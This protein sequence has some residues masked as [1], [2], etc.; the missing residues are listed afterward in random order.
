ML[1]KL[2]PVVVFLVAALTS[3]VAFE[4]R[5]LG[6]LQDLWPL[7]LG[8]ITISIF[9]FAVFRY[10]PKP[11]WPWLVF[12]L[13]LFMFLVGGVLG[14]YLHTL[15]N[16]TRTRS[17]VPDLI[18][19]PG[20]ALLA[21]GLLGFS[22]SKKI[23]VIDNFD[24]LLDAM[25]AGLSVLAVAWV[26]L[27]GPLL[28]SHGTGL[29][30]RLTL[31]S[32]PPLSAVLFVL[33]LRLALTSDRRGTPSYWLLLAAFVSMFI[34]D[35]IYMFADSDFMQFSYLTLGLPYGLAYIF[36]GACAL[37]PGMLNFTKSTPTHNQGYQ[38]VQVV[39]V[40]LSLATPA[41][42]IFGERTGT[43]ADRTVIFLVDIALVATA[44][45]RVLRAFWSAKKSEGELAHLAAHDTLTGLPNRRLVIERLSAALEAAAQNH[46][47]LALIFIDLDQF[48]LVNDSF[49]H[50]CG[51][52]LLV[53]VAERLRTSIRRN[54]LV[55]RLGGDEFLV[56]MHGVT[57][58]ELACDIAKGL[59]DC[60]HQ[61]FM[62]DG[63]ELFITGSF[64]LAL[65]G[66]DDTQ[67]E[68]LLR[69]ADTAMYQAKAAGRDTV[70]VFN[71]S[72]Q[73]EVTK[74]LEMKHDL[75]YAVERNQLFLLYQPIVTANGKYV[76]GVEALVR[77]LH[78]TLGL[79]PP[80]VFIPV[81]EESGQ[82]GDI[83][84]WVLHQAISYRAKLDL[85]PSVS[86]HLYIAVNLSAAQLTDDGLKAKVAQVLERY[87]LRGEVLCI[88]LTESMVMENPDKSAAILTSLKDLNV[89]LAIDDFGSGY[90]SLAYLTKFPVDKLK[91]D[92]SFVDSI[93]QANSADETLIAAIVAMA[94]SL[95]ISTTAEGV[96]TSSQA[97]RIRALGCDAIQGFFLSRPV[98]EEQLVPTISRLENQPN[99]ITEVAVVLGAGFIGSRKSIR[100]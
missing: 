48:K 60:L 55:A 47:A 17:L 15:G 69:D 64:G 31:V 65:A 24:A 58:L 78:P 2:S 100:E 72:M 40:S 7:V 51:D 25:M 34:G 52:R 82:I 28:Y 80:S 3:M 27:I 74:R 66:A 85:V 12:V 54:D 36:A 88:E 38:R 73:T 46:E 90:S 1:G 99:G 67:A 10:R 75:R 8:T 30:I 97:Q 29:S 61:S 14:A 71:S 35:T 68:Y 95:G 83:G 59:R 43:I 86:K 93:A 77:W 22:T 56:I 76:E 87:G 41:F 13:A 20:Y 91:I 32:Y 50:A 37:D 44:T 21:I 9:I 84:E 81:A 5:L 57:N 70:V 42:L 39:L 6:P 18:T 89:K 11:R 98:T 33:T 23:G 16:L 49:G 26:Y 79:V 45:T 63:N 62:V 53:Q 92:K 96:E 19:I 4:L 94:R